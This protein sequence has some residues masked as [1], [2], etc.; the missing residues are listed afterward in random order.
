MAEVSINEKLLNRSLDTNLS[1]EERV[2]ALSEFQA[3]SPGS[4]DPRIEQAKSQFA[5]DRGITRGEQLIG[6]GS[7][8]RVDTNLDKIDTRFDENTSAD[9]QG[10]L[11]KRKESLKG[12]SSEESLAMREQAVQNIGR[13]EE[14]NRRRLSSIQAGLG[15]RGDTAATQQAG[16]LFQGMQNRANFERDLILQNRQIK[17]DALNSLENTV[18]GNES[19]SNLAKQGNVGIQQFN[20]G[21]QLQELELQKYN[22]A[23]AAKERFGSLSVGFGFQQL[24][25]ANT[26]A[27]KQAEAQRAAA[28]ASS[29]GSK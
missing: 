4:R 9:M 7:L 21:Q 10:I 20:A 22:L 15:V 16:V 27:N 6:K 24:D 26:S 19:Q 14:T 12:L 17:A 29:G 3:M 23:Q 1:T 8:G 13:N 25:S 5:F 11:A 28:A 18:R 2:K